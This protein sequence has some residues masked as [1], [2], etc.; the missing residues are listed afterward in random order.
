MSVEFENAILAGVTLIREAIQSQNFET[1]VAGWQIQADGN[2]EFTDLI[3]RSSDGSSSTVSIANGEITIT[4]GSG[5]TVIRINASGYQL[6]DTVFGSGDVIAEILRN[7]SGYGGG[8]FW[9]RNFQFPESV[10]SALLDGSLVFGTVD[11]TVVDQPASVAYSGGG[12][13]EQ[14]TLT[15]SSGRQVNT[16]VAA[17]LGLV[18]SSTLDSR[19]QGFLT[20]DLVAD[21]DAD[22]AGN[23][24]AK[25]IQSGTFVI[26]PTVANAWTANLAVNF[27]EAFDTVPEV[28]VCPSGNGPSTG[29]TTELEWQTTGASTAGFNCRIRRGNLTATT[30][31]YIAVST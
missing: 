16:R 20:G 23:V 6:L 12:A 5:N 18:S 29:S 24:T 4:D 30:L 1:G 17:V 15:V 3:I 13:N 27:S 8:G 21:G 31:T 22:F 19:P 7:D 9:S 10:F 11:T 26:T 14:T 25:N 28:V 2:A